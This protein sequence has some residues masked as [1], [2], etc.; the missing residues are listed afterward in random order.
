MRIQR[1][2][3]ILSVGLWLAR[4]FTWVVW[5]W[6]ELHRDKAGTMSGL[7]PLKVLF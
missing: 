6:D 5:K 4:E 1:R 7:P 2:T 3:G